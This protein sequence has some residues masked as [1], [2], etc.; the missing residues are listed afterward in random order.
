MIMDSSEVAESAFL[1][2]EEVSMSISQPERRGQE[3]TI[4][5]NFGGSTLINNK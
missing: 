4:E 3:K 5:K 1:L 2:K